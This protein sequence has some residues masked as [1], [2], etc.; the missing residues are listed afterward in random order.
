MDQK[1]LWIALAAIIISVGYYDH[2]EKMAKM[3]AEAA[4]ATGH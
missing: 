2:Q 4:C 3:K 1:W